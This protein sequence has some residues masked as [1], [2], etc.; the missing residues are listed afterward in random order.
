MT[1]DVVSSNLDQC[2]EYICDN[3]CQWLTTGRWFSPFP[4]VSS[5]NKTDRNDITEMLLKVAL[6]TIKQTFISCVILINLTDEIHVYYFSS[7]SN[8]QDQYIF[9]YVHTNHTRS[10]YLTYKVVFGQTNQTK[11]SQVKSLLS[12][13]PINNDPITMPTVGKNSYKLKTPTIV[14]TSI[15][16]FTS[17]GL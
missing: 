4:P 13:C 12:Q 11:T 14:Y 3:V 9:C 5:T 6:N 10:V 7:F 16:F 1:I 17:A 8:L 15:F 2:E